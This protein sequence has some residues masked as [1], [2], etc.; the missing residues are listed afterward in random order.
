MEPAM[1]RILTALAA[2]ALLAQLCFASSG[3]YGTKDEAVAMVKRVAEMFAKRAPIRPSTPSRISLCL[4]FTIA[5][6]THSSTI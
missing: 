5:T 1:A 3:E 4:T 2:V 6:Y